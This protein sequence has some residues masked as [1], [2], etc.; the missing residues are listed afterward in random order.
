MV[1]ELLP[2]NVVGETIALIN[3]CG[4]LGGFFGTWFVG[5]LQTATGSSRAGFL[6]MSLSVI[7]SGLLLLGMKPLAA[8]PDQA[9]GETG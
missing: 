9:L 5:L 6:L 1:P 7:F 4:A 3:A 2:R 8:T